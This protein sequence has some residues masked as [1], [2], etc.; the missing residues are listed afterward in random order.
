MT[1]DVIGHRQ[2]MAA[3]QDAGVVNNLGLTPPER[4]ENER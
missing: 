2:I 3:N 4:Y 1:A